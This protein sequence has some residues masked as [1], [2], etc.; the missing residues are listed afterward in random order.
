MLTT[1]QVRVRT[2][3]VTRRLGWL[4]VKVGEV[5]NACV[6]CQGLKKGQ[7]PKVICQIR[8][9]SVRREPLKE[10]FHEQDAC[11][12]EGFPDWLTAE[13]VN[14][15]CKSHKGCF[16]ETVVTRIQFEYL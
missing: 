16:A 11:R 4:N 15:F 1:A 7:R 8:V 10:M 5:L 13:F 14:F 12:R 3:D 6:K 9:V 2:K